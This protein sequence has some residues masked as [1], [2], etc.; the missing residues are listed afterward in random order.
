MEKLG[1]QTKWNAGYELARVKAITLD[2]FAL[3]I[4]Q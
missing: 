2:I 3:L 4:D 1:R